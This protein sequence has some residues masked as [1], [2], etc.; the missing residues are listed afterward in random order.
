M[1]FLTNKLYNTSKKPANEN[2]HINS[3]EK[4]ELTLPNQLG[5]IDGVYVKNDQATRTVLVCPALMQL[6]ENNTMG[7]ITTKFYN[8][9]FDIFLFNYPGMGKSTGKPCPHTI[10]ESAKG[11]YD[12]V[13]EVKRDKKSLL[14]Y[15]R[16]MGASVASYLA[17]E[18][19][20][21]L[22]LLDAPNLKLSTAAYESYKFPVNYL[23]WALIKMWYDFTI[24]LSNY[25]K[26]FAIIRSA[27]DEVV[28]AYHSVDL[29]NR[30]VQDVRLD[31][32]PGGHGFKIPSW[33]EYDGNNVNT[34]FTEIVN[35]LF[36]KN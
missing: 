9:G 4:I 14:V 3:A 27:E 33:H 30:F 22:L 26:P 29:K 21:I 35:W 28:Q 32:M 17:D 2:L 24:D 6:Y 1:N 16:S 34:K 15:G 23:I 19:D 5:T 31:V 36:E 13:L 20:D 10:K 12:H 18:H 8:N 11:M 25:T 7:H